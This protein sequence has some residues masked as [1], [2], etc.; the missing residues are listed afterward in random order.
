MEG[1]S[2]SPTNYGI[3][4]SGRELPQWDPEYCP[5]QFQGL[6]SV[7]ECIS[8]RCLSKI[9]IL[10]EGILSSDEYA[11][12]SQRNRAAEC[13]SFGQKWKTGTGRQYFTDIIGLSSNTV[14]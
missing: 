13:I 10:S 1:V 11:Q 3:W 6:P 9:N 7:T 8:M 14:T 5:G 2:T 12:L 4:G